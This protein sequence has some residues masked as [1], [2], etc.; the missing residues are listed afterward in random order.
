[1][2]P[3]WR[4][5]KST[6]LALKVLWYDEQ[7]KR[8]CFCC[9]EFAVR[10]LNS[11]LQDTEDSNKRV[12]VGRNYGGATSF[13]CCSHSVMKGIAR[14]KFFQSWSL[15]P[16][17]QT[18]KL[19]VETSTKMCLNRSSSVKIFR[20][21]II[22]WN[23]SFPLTA[24][25]LQFLWKRRSSFNS[26]IYLYQFLLLYSCM[27]WL[28]L[29]SVC[30]RCI[31]NFFLIKYFPMLKLLMGK[32]RRKGLSMCTG[33]LRYSTGSIFIY[34]KIKIQN[35]WKIAEKIQI[36]RGVPHVQRCIKCI[37]KQRCAD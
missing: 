31:L 11:V 37:G 15:T 7:M 20:C 2:F 27:K 10:N 6:S 32:E 26:P 22:T 21:H 16:D 29:L 8:S 18:F 1:M 19:R 23:S 3:E 13:S 30:Q 35:H 24:L 36:Q 14:D 28:F 5:G 25:A 9:P 12:V 4:H 33:M 34:C 17:T